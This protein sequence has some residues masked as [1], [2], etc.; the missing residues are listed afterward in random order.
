MHVLTED[1]EYNDEQDKSIGFIRFSLLLVATLISV[2][3]TMM[4]DFALGQWVYQETQSATAYGLIGFAALA[5]QLLMAPV[6]GALIDR[7]SRALLMIVGH[8]G[9]GICTLLLLFLY[10]NQSLDVWLIIL[11]ASI[12]S[13]FNG[14]INQTFIVL[15]P[16]IVNKNQLVRVQGFIQGGMGLIEISVPAVA[17]FSLVTIGMEGIFTIDIISFITAILLILVVLKQLNDCDGRVKESKKDNKR[18]IMRDVSFGL[19]YLKQNRNLLY[20]LIFMA[21]VNF[22]I[23][24]VHVL[25]TPLVLSF[26]NVIEL[27]KVLTAAG[28]GTLLGSIFLAIWGGPKDKVKGIC[29]AL[30]IIGILLMM[31]TLIF[32]K[33]VYTILLLSTIALLITLSFVIVDGC[34]QVIWQTAVPSEIQG[35]VLSIQTV[36]SQGALPLAFL[37]A[38]P[39]ADYIFEPMMAVNGPLASSMVAVLGVGPGRGIT[40]LY[41]ICGLLIIASILLFYNINSKEAAK[42][43][44]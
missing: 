19:Q 33:D 11:L 35:R 1:T 24:V 25:F 3:G 29:F 2:L 23:G 37:A 13:V 20:L 5:P 34:N 26:S 22:S 8:A 17:A 42:R 32:I 9:A 30:L 43:V 21:V 38:G 36:V 4:T 28:V 44:V 18:S 15:T 7:Y 39:L 31:S 6:I 40:L 41:G 14:L 12:S 27:G 16:V 10:M